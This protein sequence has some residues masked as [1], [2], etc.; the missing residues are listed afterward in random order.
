MDIQ[1]APRFELFHLIGV[2]WSLYFYL[3]ESSMFSLFL[4]L[5]FSFFSPTSTMW[6]KSSVY[7]HIKANV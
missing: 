2:D 1:G 3:F 4:A 6:R 7:K 5:Y